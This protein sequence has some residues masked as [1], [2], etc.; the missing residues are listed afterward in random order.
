[1]P[2]AEDHCPGTPA[3]TPTDDSGR[4]DS[5]RPAAPSDDLVHQ[6]LDHFYV[7]MDPSCG[8]WF[9]IEAFVTSPTGTVQTFYMVLPRS[10]GQSPPGQPWLVYFSFTYTDPSPYGDFV[11]SGA[12]LTG[13]PTRFRFRVPTSAG[14]ARRGAR[15]EARSGRRR[16]APRV[17]TAGQEEI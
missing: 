12:M 15:C 4:T 9:E 5:T 11:R 1:V 14:C 7:P 2:D 3:L 6:F 13:H 16:E 10:K 8:T 17:K